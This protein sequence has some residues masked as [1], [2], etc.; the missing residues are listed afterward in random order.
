[1]LRDRSIGTSIVY[2][3]SDILF[4]GSKVIGEALGSLGLRKTRIKGTP[5]RVWIID[6]P[7][8]RFLHPILGLLEYKN[9]DILGFGFLVFISSLVSRK[10]FWFW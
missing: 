9:V 1:M 10:V 2:A 5:F 3:W 8:E 6:D 7:L 4:R